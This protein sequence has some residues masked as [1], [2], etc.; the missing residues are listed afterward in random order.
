MRENLNVLV[1]P[2]NW[3]L[4]HATRCIPIIN[5]L[6]SLGKRVF[7]ASDGQAL[8]LLR[9]EFPKLQTLELPSYGITYTAEKENFN[10]HL[11]RQIPRFIKIAKEEKQVVDQLITSHQIGLVISDNRLGLHGVN[12]TTVYIT[13]QLKIKAGA[14]SFL[15]TKAHQWLAKRHDFIWVP[16]YD[17]VR[18]LAGLLSK[19]AILK[20]ETT[21][22]G[23][24]S[25]FAAVSSRPKT[26]DLLIL[27]SGPEPLRTDLEKIILSQV[28]DYNGTVCFIRGLIESKQNKK[29]DGEITIYNFQTSGE[30]NETIAKSKLVLARSGYSTIM[31]LHQLNSTC[32]FIPTPGQKEQ[33]YLAEYLENKGVAPFCTQSKFKIELLE[34]AQLYTG[35]SKPSGNSSSLSSAIKS[36]F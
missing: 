12:A 30:L 6:L 20:R 27:L 10:W 24:L 8:E 31:D 16:D 23:P 34:K 14:W 21:Y 33:E 25:R 29:I 9:K 13:H 26:I 15:A 32:F 28:E 36:A 7:I 35:F 4:G 1:A 22:I 5:E 18:S 17:D 3:G 2:L 11:M 19:N